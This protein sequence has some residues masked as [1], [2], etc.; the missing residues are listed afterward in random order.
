MK[1]GIRN[2]P[3]T[4]DLHG[5]PLKLPG[6]DTNVVR[7]ILPVALLISTAFSTTRAQWHVNTT[8]CRDAP[9]SSGEPLQNNQSRSER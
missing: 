7:Y 2:M 3:E 4:A 6:F 1:H 8:A 5:I 9:F